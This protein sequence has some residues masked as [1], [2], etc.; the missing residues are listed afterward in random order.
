MIGYISGLQLHMIPRN[1]F[2]KKLLFIY[3]I[4]NLKTTYPLPIKLIEAFTKGG[5]I[6]PSHDGF[7]VRLHSTSI[8]RLFQMSLKIHKL[9]MDMTS[10]F[11]SLRH[12]ISVDS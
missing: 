11:E 3:K 1:S 10:Q 2:Q 9:M 5:K 7:L 12:L 6:A 8:L 4:G